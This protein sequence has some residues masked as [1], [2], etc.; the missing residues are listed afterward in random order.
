MDHE[1]NRTRLFA[2]EGLMSV[3]HDHFSRLTSETRGRES[4]AGAD[5]GRLD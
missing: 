3:I 5:D 4:K 1:V 2:T